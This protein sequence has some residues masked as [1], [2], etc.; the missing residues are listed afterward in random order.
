MPLPTQ[1]TVNTVETMRPDRIR[2]IIY[3]PPGAGKTTLASGWYPQSTLIIDVEGGTRMLPGAHFIERPQNYTQFMAL[4]NS[5]A[6]EQ[7]Q[8]TSVVIDTV[9]NLVRMADAE[10]GQRS[11]KV[12]AGLV[13]YGKGLADR[14]GTVLREIRRLTLATD[15]GVILVAH[16]KDRTIGA[17]GAEI[18]LT[19]PRIDPNDRITQEVEGLVDYILHV[20]RDHV[21]TTGGNDAVVT[22]R[23]VAL[24]D[25]MPADA[26][27]LFAAVKA[28]TDAIASANGETTTKEK[29]AA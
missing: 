15:L 24:P 23:R 10:A 18:Q 6:T 7:H 13:E 29:I 21:V 17:D 27:A 19:G 1:P 14:D 20:G 25:T 8:F 12:A 5:L 28:G 16:P 9:D 4:V 22:K 3:G 2:A 26:A 11:G